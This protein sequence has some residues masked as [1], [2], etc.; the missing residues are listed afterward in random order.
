MC[1]TVCTP[2]S[3]GDPF[4][5]TRTEALA[6]QVSAVSATDI[7][8]SAICLYDFLL[9]AGGTDPA[10]GSAAER[11]CGGRLNPAPS[12]TVAVF[13]GITIDVTVCSKFP[14]SF[15]RAFFFSV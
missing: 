13:G 1:L 9:I 15:L 12:G 3:G 2:T 4:S 5:L 10:T 14:N 8:N 11:Y 7:E 6:A